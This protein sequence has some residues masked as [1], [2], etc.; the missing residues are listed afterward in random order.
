MNIFIK[1]ILN[2]KYFKK[3]FICILILGIVIFIISKKFMILN[4]YDNNVLCFWYKHFNEIEVEPGIIYSEYETAYTIFPFWINTRFGNIYISSFSN[5][6][7][8]KYKEIDDIIYFI[9][10]LAPKNKLKYHLKILEID[11]EN[12]TRFQIHRYG[13]SIDLFSNFILDGINYFIIFINYNE[14]DNKLLFITSEHKYIY[15][16]L[17]GEIIK[18]IN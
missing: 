15:L 3:I 16:T 4:I 12:I 1:N 9:E 17:E 2:L 10:L 8:Q 7:L 6:K 5:I 13:L 11:I 14:I 18:I